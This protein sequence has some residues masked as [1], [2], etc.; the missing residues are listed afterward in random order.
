MDNSILR[1]FSKKSS[2]PDPQRKFSIFIPS[3][4]NLE[5]LKVCINS[6]RKNSHF[7]HQIIVHINE[8]S[9]GT[10]DWV[11]QQTDLD[12]TY[13]PNNI[14]ICY[15]MNYMRTVVNTDYILYLNDDMY[16]C[17]DW[18]LHLW[19]EA[20]AIGH[21]YFFLSATMIE[22]GNENVV[23]INK[24]FGSSIDDFAEKELLETYHTFEKNNWLGSTW[25]PNLIHRDLWDLVGGYSIEFS[26]GMYSDPDFSMK[27][28]KAGV[29]IFR[30]IGKSR[31]YH[32]GS[33][34][35]NRVKKN[36]GY[37]TFIRKWGTTPSELTRGALKQ[38]QPCNGEALEDYNFL[39]KKTKL[40]FK[41]M[42]ST[43]K[44]D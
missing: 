15:A 43:L 26:P 4:N 34:S 38:G 32:F 22:A 1:S 3:W 9:D 30:G 27:L 8:G 11:K 41:K 17:P 12:Y 25:P 40:L 6:I 37:H 18:D 23:T 36:K 29:R 13:S 21:H 35:T 39:K 20:Q 28:F 24:D 19:N 42:V 44:S 31:V 5:I 16:V 33:K 2:I 7:K 14:G 10:F